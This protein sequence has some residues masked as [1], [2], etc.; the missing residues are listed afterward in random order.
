[1]LAADAVQ[2]M[3]ARLQKA[4]D[5]REA[6]RP[7]SALHAGLTLEDAYAIQETWVEQQVAAGRRPVGYKLGLT[8][9]ASQRTLGTDR[10]I[11]GVLFA[12]GALESGATL[13]FDE[14][15]GPRVE[16]ELA[17]TL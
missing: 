1:M 12:D 4:M 10:P 7:A 14:L 3:A 16:L 9:E 11:Y 15:I 2:D 5:G 13:H 17:L 6:M 8:T